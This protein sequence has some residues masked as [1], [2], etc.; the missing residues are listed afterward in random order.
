MSE[1]A[2]QPRERGPDFVGVGVQKSGT[3]WAADVLAQHPGVLLRRKE[4]SF[5][6]RYFHRGWGWYEGFFAGKQGRVAGELSVNHMYSPRPDAS[7]RE[8]YPNWNPRRRLY[9]WRRSPSARDELAARYPDLRVFALFRNPVDR[10]WSHYSMWKARRE[11]NGKRTV[12]FERMFADDGRWI[13]T[14][15]L[16]AHWL[17]HWRERFPGFGAFLYDDIVNDPKT[18]ARD[19]YRFIGVDPGFEPVLDRRVNEGR[20]KQPMPEAVAALLRETYRDEILRFQE[21][22]GRDLGAWLR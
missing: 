21:R 19:L 16:Y 14:Q 8:F 18:L 11:R 20:A 12:P 2:A 22:I 3:T 1:P 17:D 4:I 13:R 10:A 7:H 5:F 6:V 15:G 9:F